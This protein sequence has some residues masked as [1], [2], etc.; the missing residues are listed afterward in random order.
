M[1]QN[2][3]K[4]FYEMSAAL[5]ALTGIDEE[6]GAA[7]TCLAQ[8]AEQGK[9]IHVFGVD[10]RAADLEGELFYRA[11][12]LACID[13]IYDPAFSN[14]HGAYRS[15]LCRPLD[16]LAP[17]ILEY[18]ELIETGDPLILLAFDAASKAFEQAAEWAKAKG[19]ALIAVVPEKPV[20]RSIVSLIDVMI[21]FGQPYK[22]I[23]MAAVLN[24]VM[25]RTLGETP[26]A[27]V[28][29]GDFFPDTQK[30]RALL[31]RWR[32]RVRHL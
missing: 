27:E 7:A 32:W 28:W 29:Q 12:G 22:T 23:C 6:I 25:A 16:G 18:Y 19:L 17:K 14:S 30:N 5:S 24:E 8:A 21:C 26:D 2:E 31:E 13:P 15:E 11:G 20:D 3:S 9:M 10:A 4:R 1:A